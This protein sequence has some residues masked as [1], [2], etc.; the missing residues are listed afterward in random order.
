METGAE[1]AQRYRK[2]AAKYSELANSGPRDIM[3]D[4]HRRL[5]ERYTRMAEDL[6]RR[7]NLGNAN[8]PIK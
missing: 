3:N 7:E 4:V 1:R 6:E 2:E 5:E 8:C